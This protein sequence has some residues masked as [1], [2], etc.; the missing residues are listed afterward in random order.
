LKVFVDDEFCHDGSALF[1]EFSVDFEWTV[2][3]VEATA[4]HGEDESAH[5][6]FGAAISV[7]EFSLLLKVKLEIKAFL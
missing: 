1:E 3:L 5:K 6:R 4:T 2:R 7:A